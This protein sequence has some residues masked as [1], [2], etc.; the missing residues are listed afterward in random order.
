[1]QDRKRFYN[2]ATAASITGF[3]RAY[4][5]ETACKCEG[6]LYSDTDSIAAINIDNVSMGS[7][8]GDWESE[9][10]FSYGAIGGKKMYAFKYSGKQEWKIASKG[11]RLS[12]DQVIEVAKGKEVIF[13]PMAPTY[14]IR[15][16]PR[17]TQ[18]RIVR[19]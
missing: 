15:H 11:A 17:F 3:V 1:M 9:G 13:D 14:S 8:L 4:L 19:T 2:I 6:L 10:D 5:W 16:E 18:R 12:A 7:N